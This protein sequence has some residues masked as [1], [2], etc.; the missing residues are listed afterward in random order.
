MTIKKEEELEGLKAVGHAV[1][2]TLKKMKEYTK[3]GMSTKEIDQYGGKLLA[4]FGAVSAPIKDYKFP[5]HTCISINNVVCHGIP[6]EDLILKEGDLVNI[7]VS[8]EMGGFY[9]DNGGSFILGKD[10][11]NHAP[12][13]KASQEILKMAIDNIK[14]GMKISNIG[15]LIEREA[16]KRGFQVIKNLCGHGIGRKLHEPPTEI[17][18]YRDR[19]NTQR[20]R[21]NSVIAL[22]TF[23]STKSKYVHEQK[24]GWTMKTKDNSFVTQHEHTLVVTDGYPIILTSENGV[25]EF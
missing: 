12:L 6:S 4:E 20:F 23:I 5:G 9:G 22:E 25:F 14:D 2:I 11:H 24:D 13:V 1:A 10:I 17:T 7:D 21:K 18:N 16:K 15:G 19:F 3:I 8:A